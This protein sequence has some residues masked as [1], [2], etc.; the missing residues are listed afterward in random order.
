[1]L[2]V[3]IIAR[4]ALRESLR[5]RF[6]L[7]YALAIAI[8]LGAA[9]FMGALALTDP[10]RARII[11][12]AALIRPLLAAQ[13]ILHIAASLTR[14]AQEKGLD[15]ILSAG[16][17]APIVVAGRLLGYG[18]MAAGMALGAGFV[19]LALDARLELGI[20]IIGLA[21][22]LALIAAFTV[23]CAVALR[24]VSSSALA[25]SIFYIFGHSLSAILLLARHPLASYAGLRPSI[26]VSP[27]ELIA[28]L[29]PRFDLF[30]SA[31]WLAGLRSGQLSP[32][33]IQTAI[34]L[35]LL[36]AMASLDLKRNREPA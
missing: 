33:L 25:A 9:L 35:L 12:L 6:W 28:W 14:E 4:T 1:M 19:L 30:G 23:A 13:L 17:P 2:T 27:V 7:I 22:E 34:Y 15:M 21:C 31:D 8:G 3:W 36:F 18:L 26:A 5:T 10:A 20:W 29:M 24:Q 11:T 16:V 32:V